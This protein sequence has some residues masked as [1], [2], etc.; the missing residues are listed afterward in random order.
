MQ[1][2]P[3]FIAALQGLPGEQDGALLGLCG[4]RRRGHRGWLLLG[5][6]G[7]RRQCP[8][9]GSK[10]G[11]AGAPGAGRGGVRRP[12]HGRAGRRASS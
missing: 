1:Q 4:I 7:D 11:R 3:D 6:L 9:D 5:R 12:L 10:L 2:N 8:G